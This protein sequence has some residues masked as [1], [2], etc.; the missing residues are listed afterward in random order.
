MVGHP[1][2]AW[3]RWRRRL[4]KAALITFVVVVALVA[5]APSLV[6]SWYLA[7]TVRGS[8]EASLGR[9]VHVGRCS[10]G[11][12]SGLVIDELWVEASDG[13]PGEHLVHM[14]GLSFAFQPWEL[15]RAATSSSPFLGR[16]TIEELVVRIVRDEQGRFDAPGSSGPPPDFKSVN[17]LDGDVH[18]IDRQ[19]GTR[20]ALTHLRITL[21][22]LEGSQQVYLTA[23]GRL[24]LPDAE[25]ATGTG[26]VS[27]NG[28]LD[29]LDLGDL[30]ATTGGC[31]ID[32]EGVDV[33]ALFPALDPSDR[34]AL[35]ASTDGQ[36]GL[37]ID[38]SD[39]IGFEVGMAAPRFVL[40]QEEA[41]P[42][43][44]I[45]RPS[46]SLK[47]SYDRA[48]GQTTLEQ[49]QVFGAGSSI[50]VAGGLVIKPT[51]RLSGQLTLSGTLSWAPL[52]Q[53][54]QAIGRTLGQLTSAAGT[55]R[56]D[57][58]EIAVEDDAVTFGGAVDLTRTELAW[59]P[60]FEKSVDLPAQLIVDGRA[61]MATGELSL[62]RASLVIRRRGHLS[63]PPGE[64]AELEVAARTVE[65]DAGPAASGKPPTG[66]HLEVR[67][68]VPEVARLPQYVPVSLGFVRRFRV[69]GGVSAVA[70]VVRR[71][72]EQAVTVRVDGG[73]AAFE[74]GPGIGK[75]AGTPMTAVFA[76]HLLDGDRL[77]EATSVELALAASTFRWTGSLRCDL[78]AG[79]IVHEG[80]IEARGVEQWMR[81]AR[82]LLPERPFVGLVGNI[83]GALRGR[84]DR[85]EARLEATVDASL[86]TVELMAASG[87]VR[88]AERLVV[89]PLGR[90]AKIRAEAVYDCLLDALGMQAGLTVDGSVIDVDAQVKGLRP[91]LADRFAAG[92]PRDASASLTVHSDDVTALLGYLPAVSAVV[93]PYK[94]GGGVHWVLAGQASE[95][96]RLR[97]DADLTQTTY[98]VPGEVTG[99]SKAAG[100]PQSLAIEVDVPRR[101]VGGLAEVT[102]SELSAA[103]GLSRLECRGSVT[104]DTDA[105]TAAGLSRAAP[106]AI[107]ALDLGAT[108]TVVQDD[109]LKAYSAWWRRVSEGS[110]FTGRASAGIS[111]AGT[112]TSGKLALNVDATSAGFQYGEGTRKPVGVEAMVEVALET[113]DVIG[114]LGLQRAVLRIADAHAS[115]RG[116]LYCSDRLPL[117]SDRPVDFVLHLEGGSEQLARL[118]Q[119][120]P[121]REF[122]H[123]EP[124]GGLE[125][126]LDVA[127]D[128]YGTE[129]DSAEFHFRKTRMKWRGADVG[130]DGHVSFGRQ[131][132]RADALSIDVADSHVV[133]V[134]D[135]A[136]PL[137][138]PSGE[139]AITGRMLD[140]DQVLAL[141]GLEASDDAS[142][143]PVGI[144]AS[145]PRLSGFF[146]R[147]NLR[148]RL[149]F[150]R[151]KWSDDKGVVYDCDAFASDIEMLKGRFAVPNFKAV[152]LGGVVIGRLGADMNAMNPVMKT[153][154]SARNL[155][156]GD[157]I[158]PLIQQ[159]F[160]DMTV[161]GRVSQTHQVEAR[162]FSTAD[163]PNYPVGRSQF[164]ATDGMLTGPGAPEWMT[165]LLPGLKL[166]TYRFK[167]M[168][169]LST[170]LP[171]GRVVNMMLF[172]G[173]PYAV[174][175]SGS[176]GADGWASYT[177]GA[178]LFNSLE[179]GEPF[180]SLEQ[181]RVP[182][183]L[184]TGRITG[185][186][187]VEQTVNYKLPHE[188]AWEVF[189][190]R[191]LLYKLLQQSGDSRRPDFKP[192]DFSNKLKP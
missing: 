160:P 119:L 14:Q 46:L 57:A 182:L 28:L 59:L 88:P 109:R 157:Q 192:Y 116:T 163:Q 181:G 161:R 183:L 77:A 48:T 78:S 66:R 93:A 124:Q 166:T 83:D 149:A 123:L 179:R 169:S 73:G 114:Q 12:F 5:L 7:G 127:R 13:R 92:W 85:Q 16:A 17:I 37:W 61:D 153:E 1:S 141:F 56:I 90:M 47:G 34:S 120:V 33:G 159:L 125:F 55:A 188:V 187:W 152:L 72:A 23:G 65:A 60:Y 20:R 130:L 154:Y 189:L 162:L 21:G 51:G 99:V 148:G 89:K 138:A 185:G 45:D 107:R 167:R 25:G 180:R 171:D 11:W 79:R 105:L 81:L 40:G 71:A 62:E 76:G 155:A 98:S 84:A 75:S 102:V 110:Q 132:V 170:L 50:A 86:A 31:D 103:T 19:A 3:R 133:V 49:M 96:L 74:T 142:P 95:R 178:D 32:W 6:P 158:A 18:F 115:A 44:R 137:D 184:Y 144:P 41:Q 15:P 87:R 52:K 174:Y 177:L 24:V 147:M 129:V 91:A 64:P 70:T 143:P 190:Q 156:G 10:L 36:A 128:R 82:P 146:G 173:S 150:D 165:N 126:S 172:D 58:L 139:F 30:G 113:T 145:W 136:S 42:D 8:L 26:L 9:G 191:N 176:T 135:L 118:A 131:R 168:E 101:V 94:P 63:D 80:Q 111:V 22:R 54:V 164:E 175:I 112:R 38:G 100:L 35:S 134:A 106:H 67:V 39:R 140:L 97:M 117:M 108:L 29:H 186:Q 53:D 69:S 121:L 151:F 122:R 43:V 27:V 2:I 68:D 4:R 104:V